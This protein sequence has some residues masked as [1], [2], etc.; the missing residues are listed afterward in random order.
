MITIEDLSMLFGV[1]QK[2]II[3]RIQSLIEQGVIK[4]VFDD[5]G[6]FLVINEEEIQ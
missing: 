2:E 3:D 1:T 4:G 5:W 6:K